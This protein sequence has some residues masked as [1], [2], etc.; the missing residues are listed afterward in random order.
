ME[1]A[2]PANLCA[3]RAP[4]DPPQQ[5][6]EEH[7][8]AGHSPY[9]SWCRACVA[10]AGRRDRHVRQLQDQ[11][12]A[13]PTLSADYAFMGAQ[14]PKAWVLPILLTK[15]DAVRWV[16]SDPVPAKGTSVSPC[17]AKCLAE[18]IVQSGFPTVI[19]KTDNEPAILEL[20]HEAVRLGREEINVEIIM[21]ES[22]DYVSETN[23][24]VELAVRQVE[25]KIRTLKFAVEEMHGV[26]IE[27]DHPVLKWAVRYAGQIMSRAHRY[28]AD[29]RTAYEADFWREGLSHDVRQETNE[30]RVPLLRGHLLGPSCKA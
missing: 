16:T 29:G 28:E 26:K 17:G 1:N 7:G 4:R 23:G 30:E 10:G 18:A 22:R 6:I 12:K 27:D 13:V 14:G 25:E 5:E 9:R 3:M 2:E 15:C 11:E 24:P 20:K 21:E 19:L 8:A